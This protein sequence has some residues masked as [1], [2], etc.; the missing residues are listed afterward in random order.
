MLLS[1]G[2]IVNSCSCYQFI[3]LNPFFV[4]ISWFGVVMHT[5]VGLKALCYLIAAFMDCLYMSTVIAFRVT[6]FHMVVYEN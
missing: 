3:A 5:P 1:D 4:V 6:A 2:G